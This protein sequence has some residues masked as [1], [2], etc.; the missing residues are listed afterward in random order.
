LY[1]NKGGHCIVQLYSCAVVYR[2][3]GSLQHDLL[4]GTLQETT[5]FFF[6]TNSTDDESLKG[7]LQFIEKARDIIPA[8]DTVYYDSWW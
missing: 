2:S 5:G 1:H 3:I 4:N 8:G 6:G 7:D